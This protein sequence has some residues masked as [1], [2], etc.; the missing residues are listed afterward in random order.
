VSRAGLIDP[1]G[2]RRETT[3]LFKPFW[4]FRR[5]GSQPL[6]RF[7]ETTWQTT[8]KDGWQPVRPPARRQL[9]MFRRSERPSWT[10]HRGGSAG[11]CAKEAS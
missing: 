10:H 7:G 4:A 8:Q 2:C 5:V 9:V 3:R 1:R 11:H 6:T